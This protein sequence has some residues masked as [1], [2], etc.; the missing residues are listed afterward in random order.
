MVDLLVG[1][2]DESVHRF[3]EGPLGYGIEFHL[4]MFPEMIYEYDQRLGSKVMWAGLDGK[5]PFWVRPAAMDRYI[6]TLVERRATEARLARIREALPH[7]QERCADWRHTR[8]N[9]WVQPSSMNIA[10]KLAEET[11]EFMRAV[12]AVEEH[13]EGRGDPFQEAA[14][15]V[16]VLLCWFGIHHPDRDLLTEVLNEMQRVGA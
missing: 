12:L 11:G 9:F 10:Y 1:T 4:R 6:E 3:A 13:R 16:L 8:G 7:L 15:V 14:Q 5:E 2:A